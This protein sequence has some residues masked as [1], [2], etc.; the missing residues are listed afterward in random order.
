MP[1]PVLPELSFEFFP[2]S[3][4][5]AT[6]RLWRA[7]E[8]LSPLGPRFVSVTYGAGGSTRD[9]TFA[10]IMTIRDRVRI[11]VAGHLTCVGASRSDTLAVAEK[12]RAMGVT[13]IVALR[14]DPPAG[15]ARFEPAQ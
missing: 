9:R 12:Y 8:R 3:N 4:T 6:L 2:P 13:R 11:P 5:S 14:G 7:V 1:N 15:Q 10:A